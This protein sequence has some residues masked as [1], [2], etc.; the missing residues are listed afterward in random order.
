M[1]TFLQVLSKLKS[2]GYT[3]DFN[4]MITLKE[5]SDALE[6]CDYQIDHWYRID[7]LSDPS[8]QTIIYAISSKSKRGVLVNG[9]GIYSDPVMNDAIQ[10]LSLKKKVF[11]RN[12]AD[13]SFH[14]LKTVNRPSAPQFF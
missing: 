3:E 5:C 7:E 4:K 6:S 1:I 13:L 10:K 14:L 8:S 9:Y 12:S 11:Q 2:D